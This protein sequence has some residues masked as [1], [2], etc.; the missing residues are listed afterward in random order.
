MI[1]HYAAGLINQKILNQMDKHILNTLDARLLSKSRLSE[2]TKQDLKDYFLQNELRKD[3]EIHFRRGSRLGANA[4]ALAG[5]TVIITDELV[6]KLSNKKLLYTIYLHEKGHLE[7]RHMARRMIQVS[8]YNFILFF[9]TNDMEGA[10]EKLA[11]VGATLISL[12]YSR[13]DEREADDYSIENLNRFEISPLCFSKAMNLFVNNSK[14]YA[15]VK[16]GRRDFLSTHPNPGERIEKPAVLFP[17]AKDCQDQKYV[18]EF[19]GPAKPSKALED[20]L[21]SP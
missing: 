10:T 5:K 19:Q 4:L 2:K 1:S 11:N 3:I 20:I 9:L 13:D 14:E 16:N 8:I 6:K 21:N 15:S 18:L 17:D 12:S 7:H